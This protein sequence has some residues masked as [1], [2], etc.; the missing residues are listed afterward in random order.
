MRSVGIG[1]TVGGCQPDK[2]HFRTVTVGVVS[3][4]LVLRLSANREEE[5]ASA[6][7][8]ATDFG[9]EGRSLR[10]ADAAVSAVVP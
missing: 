5:P 2:H 4:W 6:G 9:C 7:Y 8:P 1:G 3:D 10:R